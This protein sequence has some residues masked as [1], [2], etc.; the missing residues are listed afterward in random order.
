MKMKA[1]KVEK[2]NIRYASWGSDKAYKWKWRAALQD[3]FWAFNQRMNK[4]KNDG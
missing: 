3:A 1:G 4:P 2:K